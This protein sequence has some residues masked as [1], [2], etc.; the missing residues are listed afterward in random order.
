MGGLAVLKIA[1][2]LAAAATGPYLG[3]APPGT[4]PVPFDVEGVAPDHSVPVFAPD[5]VEVYW[6]QADQP[7]GTRRMYRSYMS[8]RGWSAP[9]VTSFTGRWD[10]DGPVFSPDGQQLYFS[11]T[12]PLA[13]EGG[14]R[15]ER[16][17]VVEREGSDWSQPRAL[18]A[19][20]NAEHLHW[21]CSVDGEGN[22]YFGADREGGQ[23]RDD[24]H[25]GRRT[26]DGFYPASS[27]SP[28][29][30]TACHESTPCVAP[31]GSYLLFARSCFGPDTPDVPTGLLVSFRLPAGAW[32]IP[33][34]VPLDGVAAE[35]AVCPTITPDGRFL[36]FLVLDRRQRSVYW[37]DAE[38]VWNL[39]PVDPPGRT[40]KGNR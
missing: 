18:P 17:W 21:R 35:D 23:G 14:H 26:K 20:I 38:V 6:A 22:V 24:I 10:A 19:E 31:D 27:L 25:V 13:S 32:S 11:S 37:V 12:R 15:R 8:A 1:V 16:L 4:T 5:R 36:F 9:A 7:D 2:A 33:V 29:L 28:P 34:P 39:N 30:N 3:Q 40:E